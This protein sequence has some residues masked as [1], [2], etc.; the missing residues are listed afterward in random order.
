MAGLEVEEILETPVGPTLF[1]K[2]TPNRGDWASVYGTA[3]EAT[4]ALNITLRTLTPPP[5]SWVPGSPE[6]SGEGSKNQENP[7]GSPLPQRG[8]GVGGE[9]LPASV[10]IEDPDGCPR[11]AAKIIRGVKIGP[12]PDWLKDRLT[13][14]LG[15]KYKPINNVVDITNY[16]MLELGQP[17]HAFDLDTLPDGK[18]VVDRPNPANA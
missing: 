2:I 4:A 10:T 16:V 14:A 6:A 11:Y 12:T 18:I 17:L 13:A 8:R 5:T 1:T 9:G 7:S 15:D 3:R